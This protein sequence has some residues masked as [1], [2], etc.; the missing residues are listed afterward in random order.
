[1]VPLPGELKVDAAVLQALPVE[2][3][4]EPCLAQQPYAAVLQHPGPLPRL[5]VGAAADLHVQRVDAALREKVGEQQPS[6]AGPD[7]ANLCPH[8]QNG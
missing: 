8:A 4:R 2:P 1:M 6:R 5:A 3:A 7:D